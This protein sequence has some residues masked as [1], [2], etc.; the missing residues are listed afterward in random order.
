[1]KNE[2]VRSYPLAD[3]HA[4]NNVQVLIRRNETYGKDGS[5]VGRRKA[6]KAN[7]YEFSS[8]WLSFSISFLTS[9]VKIFH[10]RLIVMRCHRD[11][12]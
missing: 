9:F 12:H 11:V 6:N 2:L 3:G 1:M 7:A 10:A 5:R 8:C 4:G